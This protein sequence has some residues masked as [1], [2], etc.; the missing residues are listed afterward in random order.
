MTLSGGEAL[1]PPEFSLALLK[2]AHK[3]EIHTA[4]ET[5]GGRT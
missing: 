1:M 2:A 5:S 4:I 3:N